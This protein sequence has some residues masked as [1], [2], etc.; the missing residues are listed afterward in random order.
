MSKRKIKYTKPL[1]KVSLM[2]KKKKSKC[3]KVKRTLKG[4][5]KYQKQ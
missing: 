1:N 3:Y 2:Q 5:G 4:E